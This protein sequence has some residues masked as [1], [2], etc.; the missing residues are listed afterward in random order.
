MDCE[1]SAKTEESNVVVTDND[2]A[3]IDNDVGV[4]DNEDEE[5]AAAVQSEIMELRNSIIPDCTAAANSSSSLFVTPTLLSSASSLHSHSINSVI[6]DIPTAQ[7]A[8]AVI[9]AAKDVSGP[10]TSIYSTLSVCVF[11]RYVFL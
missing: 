2:V 9:S 4:T 1:C 5:F 10:T 6:T 3:V 11:Y 7:A 8:A